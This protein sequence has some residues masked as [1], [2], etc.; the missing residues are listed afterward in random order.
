MKK[1]E[2]EILLSQKVDVIMEYITTIL[3]D[4]TKVS[5]SMKFNSAKID[6]ENMC[7]LDIYVPIN[8]FERHLNL[9]I[10]IDQKNV[11]FREFLS[12]VVVNILPHETIGATR[13][14]QLRS[15]FSLFDGITI[16]NSIGSEIKV[17]M[18][19]ID[20]NISNEYNIKYDEYK[21]TLMTEEN[22]FQKKIR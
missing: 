9:G 4:S 8:N 3:E 1:K 10:T 2:A 5:S 18:Y 16:I 11:I 21:N 13:F 12:R 6:G 19:G 20:K 17:N 7:T 14:Y 22:I 15:N